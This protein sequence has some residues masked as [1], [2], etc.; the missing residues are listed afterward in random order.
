MDYLSTIG[1]I[2]EAKKK[3]ASPNSNLSI[4]KKWYMGEPT[5][6]HKYTI[7][8]GKKN[9][10]KVRLSMHMAKQV[11]QDWASLL[12]NEKVQIGVVSQELLEKELMRV[13]F[14]NK[15]NK[16]VEYGF[17]LSMAA[18]VI[19]IE[20]LELEQVKDAD[21]SVVK[22]T[23]ETKTNINVYSALKIIPIT[24]ENDEIVECAFIKDNTE[25]SKITAHLRDENGF[26][27][28]VV[29]NV[30]TTGNT[31]E[32]YVIET[33]S[34]KPFFVIVHPQL[35]NNI[36]IDS[37]YP[38]PIFA[39]AIDSL[40]SI[41]AKYDSYTNEFLLGR[42]RI[43]VSSELNQVNK[44]TGEV[45]MNFDTNDAVFSSI[46]KSAMLNAQNGN[47]FIYVSNDAL[48]SQ[49]HSQALQDEINFFSKLC[50]LGVDYYRFE[51]G[52]VMTATQVISEK[53]DTFRN[54]KKHEGIFEKALIT[55]ISSFMYAHNELTLSEE[56]FEDIE[57]VTIQFDDSI[58]ED[59]NTEKTNDQKDVQFG[60]MSLVAYRMKWFAEDEKTAVDA[61]KEIYGDA[62]LL[63]RLANFTP[64]LTQGTITPLQFVKMVY[65]DI[66]DEAEQMAL[67][68]EIKE[69]LKSG[70][71]V[72]SDAELLDLRTATE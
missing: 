38:I 70:G 36:D 25:G 57:N 1:N 3:I 66:K 45:E 6:W 26:Y 30:D 29:A 27:Q 4:W 31:T 51:K 19:D 20:N 47:P 49:E 5:S 2:L 37:P 7:Y 12:M 42:K 40:K 46:P 67:A 28:I 33:K 68:D 23:N 13:N 54:L 64:F 56:K 16:S 58:I 43:F 22:I 71:E 63:K 55:I 53:S 69:N 44:D 50:D 34:K 41:D 15:A 61:V 60:A 35:V 52:R 8:N 48:R 32:M 18:L 72:F 14:Y 59:K 21:Y 9:I 17:G 10:H 39:N 24:F 11:A 65:I 62:N